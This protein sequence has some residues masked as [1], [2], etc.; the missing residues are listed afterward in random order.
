MIGMAVGLCAV[1]IFTLFFLGWFSS[2]DVAL[3]VSLLSAVG[4]VL[5]LR[6]AIFRRDTAAAAIA[7]FALVS[8]LASIFVSKQFSHSRLNGDLITLDL[9]PSI[10]S[11]WRRDGEISLPSLEPSVFWN[12]WFA[13]ENRRKTNELSLGRDYTLSI[14]LSAFDYT[15]LRPDFRASSMS[16]RA[17]GGISQMVSSAETQSVTLTIKPIILEGSGL[18]LVGEPPPAM[19]VD[20]QKLRFPNAEVAEQTKNALTTSDI[21]EELR[22]GRMAFR[23]RTRQEGCPK[24]AFAVFDDLRPLDHLVLRTVV[25]DKDGQLPDCARQAQPTV[26]KLTGGFDILRNPEL[27]RDLGRSREV[28]DAA[29][30]IF[31]VDEFHSQAVF[32]DGRKHDKNTTK[33]IYGWQTD[34]SV[35]GYLRDSEFEK[36]IAQARAL[37]A[38]NISGAYINAASDLWDEIFSGSEG[39]Q[40]EAKDASE[41]FQDL[42]KTADKSP[43]LIVRIASSAG[44]GRLRSLFA[45]L[46]ILGAKGIGAKLEQPIVVVQP[47]LF[48]RQASDRAC[49]GSWTLALPEQIDGNVDLTGVPDPLPGSRLRTTDDFLEFLNPKERVAREM[50][51]SGLVVLAHQGSGELWFNEADKHVTRVRRDFAPGSVGIMSTCSLAAT[52]TRTSQLLDNLNLQGFDTLIASPFALDASYGVRFAYSFAEAI[53]EAG[54][55]GEEATMIELFDSAV[56]K[57]ID[58][59]AKVKTGNYQEL[60][61]EYVLLGNPMARLCKPAR[62]AEP[63]L[64]LPR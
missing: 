26:A 35:I 7:T 9:G 45:P 47:L 4:F 8:F 40:E 49:I 32:V 25:K 19:Q 46:G 27:D 16:A 15:A 44:S 34:R 14:D 18:A 63:G 10:S 64:V 13:E 60:G 61:L 41:A 58:K 23:L 57:T 31:D 24:I 30:Y 29:L 6:L 2:I 12:V 39:S 37:A 53:Q 21:P 3:L 50:Q 38:K 20:L 48:E 52:T 56:R 62:P 22:A 59:F 17:E 43:V 1:A 54:K 11:L 55:R 42:V 36:R 28:G 51:P 33:R 5:Q